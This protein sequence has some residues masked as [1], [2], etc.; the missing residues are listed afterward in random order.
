MRLHNTLA[1]H[2]MVATLPFLFIQPLAAQVTFTTAGGTGADTF[3]TNDSNSGPTSVRGANTV[4]NMRRFDGTR[5]RQPLFRFDIG[6]L[7]SG[8][9]LT[10]TTLSLTIT[11]SANRTRTANVYGLIDEALDSWPESTTS[12][13][14][15]PGASAA[16]AGNYS[17]SIYDAVNNPTG[18]YK[19]LGTISFPAA[20]SATPI[21]SN[22]ANLNLDSFLDDDTNGLVTFLIIPQT[23]DS[24]ADWDIAPK[25]NTS[26]APPLLT[27]P[28][29]VT[30]SDGDG[31][32]DSWEQLYFAN[33]PS[34][35][36]ADPLRFNGT[37][38][39]DNDGFDN[40]TEETAG[41]DPTIP[42]ANLV[43]QGGLSSNVWD[44]AVTS[45]WLD[46][47]TPSI[48]R[49][50]DSVAFTDVGSANSLVNIASGIIPS[51]VSVN[52]NGDY[53]IGGTGSIT[54]GTGLT[55][56]G[57]GRL[58]LSTANSYRGNTV[59]NQGIVTLGVAGSIPG[60]ATAGSVTLNG[61][62]IDLN[63]FSATFKQFS[64]GGVVDTTT[65][66]ATVLTL[67]NPDDSMFSGT[68][69]N[70]SGTL[71]VTKGGVGILTLNG[72]STHSGG[73]FIGINNTG[74]R[75]GTIRAASSQALGSGP[76]TIG[77][78]GND[79]SA[80]LEVDAG[81]TL[82]NSI[83]LPGRN[84]AS[85]IIDNVSG[86][87]SLTGAFTL[88]TGGTEYSIES[89]AGLL[90]LGSLGNPLIAAIPNSSTRNFNLGGAGNG[91]IAGDLNLTNGN[92]NMQINKS[93]AG[94]W[95]IAGALDFTGNTT[96]T[97]GILSIASD[98]V[99]D[100]NSTVTLAS[101]SSLNLS[102]S[103]TDQV[104]ALIINNI[105]QPDGVYTFGS[106]KLRV[107]NPPAGYAD[108][109]TTHAPTGTPVDDFDG[110]GVANAVEYVLGGTKDSQ[111]SNKLPTLATSGGNLVLTFVRD[112][113]SID[114]STSLQVQVGTNLVDWTPGS[115]YNVPDAAA[116]ASPGVSVTKDSPVSGKDTIVL[117]ISQAPD[118]RK[119]ARLKVT[120]TP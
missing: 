15:A 36:Q 74:T 98:D 18:K 8:A 21:V 97:Q 114:G 14:N 112:Q 92:L 85:R 65:G 83:T 37:E 59:V 96:V 86:N 39:P 95:T 16:T 19:L 40:E 100:D 80:T 69:Q 27:L 44:T 60:G 1:D 35:G 63:G 11:R 66:A 57:G 105:T 76:V 89:A 108:W 55:K 117:S 64:G 32:Q 111:D 26:S 22:T 99:F 10:G 101:N 87:N 50:G 6:S 120:T 78:G 47:V 13:S 75:V 7:S 79:A 34:P 3:L 118:L 67:S 68:F 54:G 53:T 116:T 48:F 81:I 17:Y 46:G 107:G 5:S 56:S 25:E 45:N 90:T 113:L 51:S 61:G 104:G 4:M 119:F 42:A 33:W 58:T 84:N 31:L 115:T 103:G 93:G 43:W 72:N 20:A 12:Y 71:S 38:N 41:S 88:T 94:A 70:T 110:D 102:H 82:T 30:D 91:I 62:T 73:T 29:V 2:A 24:T 109:A 49:V 77:F 52:S 9:N 23:T 28:N 106:G